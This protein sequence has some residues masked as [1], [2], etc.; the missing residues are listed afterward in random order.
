MTTIPETL[1][2]LRVPIDS[3][4]ESNPN[5][6]AADVEQIAQSLRAHGQYRPIVVNRRTSRVLAGNHTHRAARS[7]GWEEIAATFVDVSDDE[8]KRILLI[9][10]RLPDLA[11]YDDRVLA[12][13]LDS[14][15]DLHDTGYT[16]ADLNTLLAT[17]TPA[18]EDDQGQL[19]QLIPQIVTC[20]ACGHEFAA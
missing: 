10:N 4:S 19:D 3:V 20:P 8:A 5:P 14:L 12:E 16:Q 15:G 7:L 6:R 13:L 18:D 17:F 11:V 2:A 9:D 1:D